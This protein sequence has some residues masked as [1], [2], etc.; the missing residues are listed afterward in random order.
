MV[1]QHKP[2]L[3]FFLNAV[4][5]PAATMLNDQSNKQTNALLLAAVAK[6]RVMLI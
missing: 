4:K 5:V 2:G 6:T 1:Q 3:S